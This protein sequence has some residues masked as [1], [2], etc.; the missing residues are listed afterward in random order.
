VECAAHKQPSGVCGAV[1]HGAHATAYHA[2]R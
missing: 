1:L 2:L